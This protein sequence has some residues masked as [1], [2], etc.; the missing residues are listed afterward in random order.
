M[1]KTKYWFLVFVVPLLFLIIGFL[2]LS[3]YGINWDEPFHFL[4]GQ[5]YLNFFF[6]GK[7]DYSSLSPYPKVKGI[8]PDS[9]KGK[10]HEELAKEFYPKGFLNEWRSYYQDDSYTFDDIIKLENGH[11]PINGIIASFT[12]YVFFQRLHI[13]GDIESYHFFEVFVSFLIVL[14]IALS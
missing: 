7:K 2:T 8:L 12:N 5:A 13:L 14:D 9:Q 10:V 6:T 3:D 1:R 4:R 11:P